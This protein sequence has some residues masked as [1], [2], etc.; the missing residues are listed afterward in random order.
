M[1]AKVGLCARA[2][3]YEVRAWCCSV[4]KTTRGLYGPQSV[5]IRDMGVDQSWTGLRVCDLGDRTHRAHVPLA[6]GMTHAP[7]VGTRAMWSPRAEDSYK[8]P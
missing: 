8:R 1:D 4:R 3:G 2:R 5:C 7:R 6:G